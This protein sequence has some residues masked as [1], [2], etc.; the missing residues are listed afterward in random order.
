MANEHHAAYGAS[1]EVRALKAE[2]A[3]LTKTLEETRAAAA[4]K[5]D[6]LA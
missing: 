6:A 1:A 2:I 3:S 4:S 5:I